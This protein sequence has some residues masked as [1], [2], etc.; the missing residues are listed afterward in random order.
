M[1]AWICIAMYSNR[2]FEAGGKANF[3]KGITV[4]CWVMIIIFH[5]A[6]LF[7]FHKA[8]QV[9]SRPLHLTV[10]VSMPDMKTQIYKRKLHKTTTTT[11]ATTTATH[12]FITSKTNTK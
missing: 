11:A 7:V 1:A 4:F 5:T 9:F 12:D 6:F 8:K 3:F 10:I 2:M